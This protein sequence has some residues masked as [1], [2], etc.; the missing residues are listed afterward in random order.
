MNIGEYMIRIRKKSPSNQTLEHLFLN[1]FQESPRFPNFI[2]D[3]LHSFFPKDK[4]IWNENYSAI[5]GNN[6]LCEV[7]ISPQNRKSA[8]WHIDRL[9]ISQCA[10]EVIIKTIKYVMHEYGG[11]GVQTFIT[12]VDDKMPPLK[13]LFK[14]G[15]DFMECARIEIWYSP[16]TPSNN[17]YALKIFKEY[18][19]DYLEQIVELYNEM[20]FPQYRQYL[21]ITKENFKDKIK[22]SKMLRVLYDEANSKIEGYFL[23]F[24]KNEKYYLELLLSESCGSYYTEIVDY[25]T[26]Y[27][28]KFDILVKT[29]FSPSRHL[30][31]A[32]MKK[33]LGKKE[34]YAILIKDYWAPE[35]QED[36]QVVDITG[37]QMSAN[38]LDG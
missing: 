29:Y 37:L 14:K 38:S 19:Q 21:K 7:A 17:D 9:S 27:F 35:K 13:N 16:E 6:V 24:E 15:C 23:I 4:K 33:Q 32:L 18:N 20:I 3:F 1:I 8:R 11:D 31:D 22:K 5:D 10:D 25:C 12:F 26:N 36:K 2:C 30:K 34:S 28:E